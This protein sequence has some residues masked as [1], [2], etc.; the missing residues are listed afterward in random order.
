MSYQTGTA[1]GVIDLLDKLRI[2]AVAEG[3]TANRNVSTD[4]GSG[5]EVCLSKGTSYINMKA[6]ENIYVLINGLN[7]NNKY[8]LSINGSD[9]YDSGSDWD[10][11]PG[12]SQRTS[13]GSTDQYVV[14]IPFVTNFTSFPAYHFFSHNTGDSIHLEVE[15]T[16]GVFLRLGFG[17]L[18][19]YDATTSG[20]GRYF[21]A[22][23][24]QHVTDSTNP[25]TWLGSESGSDRSLE[26]APFS[27]S[28]WGKVNKR[29]GSAVRCA[30]DA[31]DNWAGCAYQSSVSYL[32]EAVVA[33]QDR[34]IF[35]ASPNPLNG[36]GV[37]TPINVSVVRNG[38]NY[39]PLG[40]VPGIRYIDMTNYLPGDEFTLGSDT[41]KV[42]P[43]YNKGGRSYE[44]GIAHLKVV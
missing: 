22:T 39:H 26:E 37:L 18:D 23:G 4:S 28:A 43:W 11:Q 1:T 33:L 27:A 12:Y 21:Y 6:S 41:Y 32:S 24:G 17:K 31:F 2:F 30:F 3:W 14:H 7:Q 40:V 19:L 42:F 9:S 25:N 38:F 20:D 36:V 16:T 5:Q 15:I 10:R 8:S 35:M 34:I 29:C 44:L 13:G